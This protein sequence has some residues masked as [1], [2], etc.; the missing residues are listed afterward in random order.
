MDG[1]MDVCVY[2]TAN[3]QCTLHQIGGR[4]KNLARTTSLQASHFT[5]SV[6]GFAYFVCTDLGGGIHV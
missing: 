6:L 1:W 5:Y 2:S 3:L 4:G